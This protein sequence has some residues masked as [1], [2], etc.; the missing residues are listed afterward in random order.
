MN[1][2][3]FCKIFCKKS[4]KKIILG[5]SDVW[6]TIRLSNRPS[7]PAWIYLRLT[8]FWCQKSYYSHHKI[9]EKKTLSTWKVFIFIRHW[10][11]PRRNKICK[12]PPKTY[13]TLINVCCWIM[14]CCFWEMLWYVYLPHTYSLVLLSTSIR[15]DRRCRHALHDN[16]IKPIK[17]GT[18][19]WLVSSIF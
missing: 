6:S 5:T 1:W 7:N 14:K 10:T 18:K 19:L 2:K 9:P 17:C 11:P 16:S 13:W 4:W 12:E 3:A 8:D 15:L